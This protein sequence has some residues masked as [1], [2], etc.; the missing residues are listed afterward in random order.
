MPNRCS[1]T[2]IVDGKKMEIARFVKYVENSSTKAPFSF[3]TI[4]SMPE[5]L[6]GTMSPTSIVTQEKYDNYDE[7]SYEAGLDK[8]FGIGRPI[9]QEMSDR[10]MKQYNADNWC[11]WASDNWGTKWELPSKEVVVSI[12]STHLVYRFDTAWSPPD[13]IYEELVKQFPKL[14]ID[15]PYS[16][17][18]MEWF[19]N[20]A[21]DKPRN[22]QS[23]KGVNKKIAEMMLHSIK[24]ESVRDETK[25]GP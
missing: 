25:V 9:T 20:L 6:Q 12:D 19:G 4:L 11:D 22:K 7:D 18:G 15:W 16:E 1:N 3:Q 14:T 23:G 2:V 24:Q 13:G 8:R 10:F 5:E 21:T 17:E